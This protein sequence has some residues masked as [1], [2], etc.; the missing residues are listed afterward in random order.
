M[1]SKSWK[2]TAALS[3]AVASVVA[4]VFPQA[5]QAVTKTYSGTTTSNWDDADSWNPANE[6]AAADDVLFPSVVPGTGSTVTLTA[7]E[8][9]NSLTFRNT[10]TLTGGDLTLNSPGRGIPFDWYSVRWTGTITAPPERVTRIAVEGNDG[11]RLYL[12]DALVIDNWVKRSFSRREA[13]VSWPPG[14]APRS[15]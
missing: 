6:P 3:V 8:V 14:S 12:D 5:A 1:S 9:A 15:H 7:G 11:F 2:R 13:A 4:D 10:Y